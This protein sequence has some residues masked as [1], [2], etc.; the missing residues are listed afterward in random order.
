[1]KEAYAGKLSQVD[2]CEETSETDRK[3]ELACVKR[4]LKDL[5]PICSDTVKTLG[6]KLTAQQ[7]QTQDILAQI[8]VAPKRFNASIMRAT[9]CAHFEKEVSKYN[10][11]K[12]SGSKKR[13][14]E[15]IHSRSKKVQLG[16][17]VSNMISE[18]V[19]FVRHLSPQALSAVLN[20]SLKDYLNS[21]VD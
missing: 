19:H 12:H 1:M 20:Q 4:P 15:I 10:E 7:Q 8:S 17:S 3:K 2:L 13:M 6:P 21:T 18:L 5:F 14:T 9:R 11:S 16:Q